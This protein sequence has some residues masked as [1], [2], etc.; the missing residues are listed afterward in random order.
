VWQ[1]CGDD[2]SG[3]AELTRRRR[4]GPRGDCLRP[5]SRRTRSGRPD[6]DIHGGDVFDADLVPGAQCSV[7]SAGDGAEQPA[8]ELPD[9]RGIVTGYTLYDG[10]HPY[11]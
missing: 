9:V 5:V 10:V 7:V 11:G 6:L 2:A 4:A 1:G 3:Q 8:A